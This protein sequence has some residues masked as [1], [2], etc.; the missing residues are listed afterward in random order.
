[1][2]QRSKTGDEHVKTRRGK[3]VAPKRQSALKAAQRRSSFAASQEAD[4]AQ[5]VRER[6]EA[7][8]QLSA[9]SEVLQVISLPSGDLKPVL[10]T[11]LEN[12]TRICQAQFGTLNLYDGDH[13]PQCCTT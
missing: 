11:I 10:E 4:A 2:K 5:L 6:D 3:T 9:A 8:E 12:A 7:L 13:I 1:M